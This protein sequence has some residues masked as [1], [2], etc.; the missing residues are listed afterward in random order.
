MTTCLPDYRHE[1]L[2]DCEVRSLW[3]VPWPWW[4]GYGPILRTPQCEPLGRST[5]TTADLSILAG[6]TCEDL[7]ISAPV[8]RLSLNSGEYDRWHPSRRITPDHSPFRCEPRP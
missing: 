6:Q 5:F 7:T 1:D 2:I 8:R 3:R 4:T